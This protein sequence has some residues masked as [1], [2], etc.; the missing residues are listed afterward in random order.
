M[1]LPYIPFVSAW[2]LRM[3]LALSIAAATV[4]LASTP[5]SAFDHA[6]FCAA[7]TE[8]AQAGQLE[9]GV[10]PDDYTKNESI[11]VRCSMRMIEFRRYLTLPP[12]DLDDA[13]RAH[14]KAR[15]NAAHCS[16]PDWREAIRNGW[17]IAATLITEN[18]ERIWFAASCR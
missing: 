2:G 11:S 12:V 5:A 10:W 17:T 6:A 18:G 3:R 9:A 8:Y 7:M 16:D 14:E 13:W 1:D 15:W 4:A